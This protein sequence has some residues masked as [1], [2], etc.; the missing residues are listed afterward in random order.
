MALRLFASRARAAETCFG[1]FLRTNGIEEKNASAKWYRETKSSV[2]RSKARAWVEL[3]LKTGDVLSSS[4]QH[5]GRGGQQLHG[6]ARKP[7]AAQRGRRMDRVDACERV[8]GLG[9]RWLT[10][11]EA[12]DAAAATT[13][14]DRGSQSFATS[15]REYVF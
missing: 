14:A 11:S 7:R 13:V 4:E 3:L 5:L 6:D 12:V 1:F 15:L 10:V 9:T 8:D 2:V